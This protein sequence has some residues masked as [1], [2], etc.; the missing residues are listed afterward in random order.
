MIDLKRVRDRAEKDCSLRRR[1]ILLIRRWER[2][3]GTIADYTPEDVAGFRRQLDEVRRLRRIAYRIAR[4]QLRGGRFRPQ[5]PDE[6]ELLMWLVSI[7]DTLV[8]F[9][10]GYEVKTWRGAVNAD[11]ARHRAGE[12]TL[13][14]CILRR[15]QNSPH[16]RRGIQRRFAFGGDGER[17]IPPPPGRR[18]GLKRG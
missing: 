2:P 16:C 13:Q 6:F 15:L 7:E 18:G 4:K 3:G 10:R 12:E 14:A 11:R 1:A 9:L 17:S 5:H 8:L